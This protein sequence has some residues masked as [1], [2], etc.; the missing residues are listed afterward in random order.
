ML[1]IFRDEWSEW[2]ADGTT[3]Q[4]GYVEDAVQ[5]GKSVPLFYSSC[6]SCVCHT[7]IKSC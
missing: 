1:L 3:D 4:A 2:E 6:N 7:E 5:N